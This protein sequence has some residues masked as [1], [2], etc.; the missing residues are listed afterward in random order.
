[1]NL[2]AFLAARLKEPSSYAGIGMLLAA[3]GAKPND[4]TLQAIV[5]LCA[6]I[7]GLVAVLVPEHNS[8]TKG[9]GG[10]SGLP[11]AA[12]ALLI[13]AALGLGACQ[14][15][16]AGVAIAGG[17]ISAAASID[18]LVSTADATIADACA[19]YSNAKAAA[20]AALAAGLVPPVAVAKL[21]AI[22]G[23][24]DAAC[25]NPPRGDAVSTA[26]WLGE[27]AGEV[28]TLIGNRAR[29]NPS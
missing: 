17:A 9:S 11:P 13:V 6:A 23:F 26:I 8:A 27:L 28:T 15:A 3:A 1:M 25:A 5:Q 16:G 19:E 21:S 4:M 29:T 14:A 2:L 12:I 18:R 7:A 22:E 20:S 10:T 24:G